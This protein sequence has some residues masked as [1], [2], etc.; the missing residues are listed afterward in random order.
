M[1]TFRTALI[2][3]T[4]LALS[5]SASIAATISVASGAELQSAI[6]NAQP[7]D[8]ILL[9]R[10]VVY[11]GNFTLTDKGPST[12]G[13]SGPSTITIRTSGDEG[14]AG[15]GERVLPTMAPLLA[16]IQSDNS[17]SAILTAPGAHHWRLM[18]LEVVGNG[19]GELI[20]L[21]DG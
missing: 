1:T 4:G 20:A 10:G 7:G 5:S 15:E 19:F 13:L 21:G 14:L 2:L 16:K 8:T 17:A 9:A 18:L 3:C 12:G 11:T 6:V